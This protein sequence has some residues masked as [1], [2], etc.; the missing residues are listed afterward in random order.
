MTT[1]DP[2]GFDEA[3]REDVFL[4]MAAVRAMPERE[5]L[6]ATLTPVELAEHDLAAMIEIQ[7]QYE[8]GATSFPVTD[9][10]TRAVVRLVASRRADLARLRGE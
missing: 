9:A 3:R 1:D 10:N 7:R 8:A 2:D 6:E 5:A 4:R